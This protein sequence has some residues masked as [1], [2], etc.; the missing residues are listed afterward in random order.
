[1]AKK[2]RRDDLTQGGPLRYFGAAVW[3]F[4]RPIVD[5]FA[6]RTYSL[7]LT[8]NGKLKWAGVRGYY[9]GALESYSGVKS[10]HIGTFQCVLVMEDGTL[11]SLDLLQEMG[12]PAAPPPEKLS[13][14]VSVSLGHTHGAAVSEDGSLHLWGHFGDRNPLTSPGRIGA[15][16]V[17]SGRD[18]VLVTMND[19]TVRGY[20]HL[21]GV[22]GE[23]ERA[24][25]PVDVLS[26]VV[27]IA[28]LKGRF[29]GWAAVLQD[30]TVKVGGRYRIPEQF[31]EVHDQGD[32]SWNE[33][34]H[35]WGWSATSSHSVDAMKFRRLGK[36]WR[37]LQNG[38]TFH[39]ILSNVTSATSTEDD[40][41]FRR[42]DGALIA[43]GSGHIRVMRKLRNVRRISGAEFHALAACED[44]TVVAFGRTG[45]HFEVP[46]EF[47]VESQGSHKPITSLDYLPEV[48]PGA[49]WPEGMVI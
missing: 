18:H 38:R 42:G 39:P 36:P 37:H 25:P 19:G 33:K 28:T 3:R 31:T 21:G 8:D 16:A 22:L 2:R 27:T 40:F 20:G 1:M 34:G 4:R 41:L 6:G 30:G 5:V 15:R 44:G 14:I 24:I 7:L 13:G 23:P 45:P 35:Q 49:D 11:R 17:T 43:W 47:V 32:P 12:E 29:G 46:P 48:E 10:A 9:S 26:G